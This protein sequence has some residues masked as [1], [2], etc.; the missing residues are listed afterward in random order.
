MFHGLSDISIYLIIFLNH[1]IFLV[2]PEWC[3]KKKIKVTYNWQQQVSTSLIHD[4]EY[5]S[6]KYIKGSLRKTRTIIKMSNLWNTYNSEFQITLKRTRELLSQKQTTSK[7]SL[8]TI[9]SLKFDLENLL[10]NL[11]L[12]SGN[13][14]EERNLLRSM[15][16]TMSFWQSKSEESCW[17]MEE[18]THLTRTM[19]WLIVFWT[20]TASCWQKQETVWVT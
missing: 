17:E 1:F 11:D 10:K 19:T 14:Q 16:S 5:N 6:F 2:V 12:E 15:L 9:E 3:S 8:K 20:K 4:Q 18:N 13:S 7:E